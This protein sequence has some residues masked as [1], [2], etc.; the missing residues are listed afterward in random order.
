MLLTV[1]FKNSGRF[2]FPITISACL[3]II[4]YVTQ[5]NSA[6]TFSWQHIPSLKQGKISV[7]YLYFGILSIV[8]ADLSKWEFMQRVSMGSMK[9]PGYLLVPELIVRI[10]VH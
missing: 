6:L 2:F 5:N 4:Q 1:R 9:Q 3:K 10:A 7:L 8:Y